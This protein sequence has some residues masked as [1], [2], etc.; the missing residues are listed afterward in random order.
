MLFHRRHKR[1]TR[2]QHLSM[3]WSSTPHLYLSR[4]PLRTLLKKKCPLHLARRW[5]LIFRPPPSNLKGSAKRTRSPELM[6]P[7]VR[8]CEWVRSRF[9]ASSLSQLIVIRQ[10]LPVR[11]S[12]GMY[13]VQEARFDIDLSTPRRLQGPREL[14]CFCR[15]ST[16]RD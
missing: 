4:L 8:K 1:R 16:N 11:H 7:S 12:K 5:M 3:R 6:V 14:H 10:S 9:I 15:G 13:L 2:Q